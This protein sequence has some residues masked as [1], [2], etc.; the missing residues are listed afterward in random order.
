MPT[1]TNF[2]KPTTF[3]FRMVNAGGQPTGIFASGPKFIRG[4]SVM[5]F[6]GQV[7]THSPHCTQASS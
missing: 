7:A 4:A 2:A 6:S 3:K 1:T 5:T